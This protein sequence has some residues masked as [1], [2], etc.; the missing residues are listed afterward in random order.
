[1]RYPFSYRVFKI[2]GR[3]RYAHIISIILALV[4]PLPGALVHL[5]G[6]FVLTA[7]PTVVCAGRSTDYNYYTIVLPLSI[8]L[9]ITTCLIVLIFWTVLKVRITH[10]MR[11]SLA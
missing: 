8:V 2:S 10:D 3:I 4:I 5:K 6:G 1:M 11:P 7:S 9:T